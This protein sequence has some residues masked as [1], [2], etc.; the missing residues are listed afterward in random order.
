MAL[1]SEDL[2]NDRKG[3]LVFS[4]PEVDVGGSYQLGKFR[5]M[6]AV[7]YSTDR[8]HLHYFDDTIEQISDR[9]SASYPGQQARIADESWDRRSYIVH[10]SS[11][12]E[13]GFFYRFDAEKGQLSRIS[14]Q[15]PKLQGISLSPMKPMYYE[16]RD[17]KR[18]PGYLTLP[19][20]VP[21]GG[22][23]A[24]VLPHGG[25]ESRDYW[26]YDWLP[27]F[28]SARGYAVL[29]SNYRG[30]GGL[31]DDWSGQG[32]FRNWRTAIDDITD[33]ARHLVESGVADPRRLCIVGWSYGGYAALMSA[34]E[35]PELYRCVVSIAGVT[36][37]PM[38]IEDSREYLGWRSAKEFIG[39]DQ[40]V[41]AS[42][43]P[44]RRADEI[45]A[46]V[47][48]FHGDEDINVRI[49]HSE[50]M[51]RA[52]KRKKKDVEFV[53]YE[54]AEHGI[55]RNRYRVDMLDR[56]GR[57]LDRNTRSEIEAQ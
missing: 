9:I 30:S 39:K 4:H 41:L 33:G 27:Q 32:G 52:L 38:L 24:V 28:L 35:E 11:D 14:P 50:K 26:G 36:D 6:V 37:L 19:A 23:P 2:A 1:W 56:I 8:N 22:M 31:G 17:G 3:N 10:I 40:N 18:I 53:E 42:G 15:Y 47:L 13:S 45:R 12:R 57:F 51:A 46:P 5:R 7:G 21:K 55:R 34:V 25:P 29:Q 16:A 43:S 48:F 49:G 20:S 44:A 54:E